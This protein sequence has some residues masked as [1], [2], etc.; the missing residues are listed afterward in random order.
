MLLLEDCSKR[1]SHTLELGVAVVRWVA[2]LVVSAAVPVRVISILSALSISQVPLCLVCHAV[3]FP[4]TTHCVDVVEGAR[5]RERE[6]CVRKGVIYSKRRLKC[7]QSHY[8]TFG[9]IS[10]Q[11]C[12]VLGHTGPSS[13]TCVR[14]SAEKR[15]MVG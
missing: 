2:M 12:D 14:G 3:A 15:L 10:C 9:K 7:R 6:P 1:T 8:R 5:E 13:D 4:I 11:M